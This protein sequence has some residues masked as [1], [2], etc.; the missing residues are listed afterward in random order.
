MSAGSVMVRYVEVRAWPEH[1]DV[2]VVDT[3]RALVLSEY[4]VDDPPPGHTDSPLFDPMAAWT[5]RARAA[6]GDLERDQERLRIHFAVDAHYEV[7]LAPNLEPR[8]G[9]EA[10]LRAFDLGLDEMELAALPQHAPA[11]WQMPIERLWELL[12]D[13][14]DRCERRYPAGIAR[15]DEQCWVHRAHPDRRDHFTHMAD[16]DRDLAYEVFREQVDVPLVEMSLYNV[17]AWIYFSRTEFAERTCEPLG[18]LEAIGCALPRG[19]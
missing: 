11:L 12:A 8:R 6:L 18:A 4:A 15:A 2:L 19:A 14:W 1:T 16:G 17:L 7:R 9:L 5:L 13:W 10:V 3:E